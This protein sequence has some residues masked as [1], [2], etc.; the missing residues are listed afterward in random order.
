MAQTLAGLV[1]VEAPE[2]INFIA[3]LMP[4]FELLVAVLLLFGRTRKTGVVLAAIFHT[5]LIATLGPWGLDHHLGVLVWN[6]FFFLIAAVLFWP[7]VVEHNELANGKQN[8]VLFAVTIAMLL[9]PMLPHC[10]HWIA[11]GLYSPNNSRCELEAVGQNNEGEAIFH[12]I[13]L[14]EMSLQRLNVPI[15]PSARF[16]LGVALAIQEKDSLGNRS[17]IVVKSRSNRLTGQ[18]ESTVFSA[19]QQ[20]NKDNRGFLFNWTPRQ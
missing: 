6:L 17:R 8:A 5:A 3:A 19:D 20:W 2:W 7:S 12:R 1:G 11:W 18:R 10:D 4:V 14:G 16:Q 9:Y 13:D 15:Y